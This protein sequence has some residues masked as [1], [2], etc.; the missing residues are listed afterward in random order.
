[1]LSLQKIVD[2]IGHIMEQSVRHANHFYVLHR[3]QKEHHSKVQRGHACEV[4]H[5]AEEEYRILVG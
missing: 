2:A 5:W 1:M 3:V 4:L